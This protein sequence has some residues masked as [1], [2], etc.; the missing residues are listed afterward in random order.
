MSFAVCPA[1]GDKLIKAYIDI[2]PATPLNLMAMKP[3]GISDVCQPTK[4]RNYVSSYCTPWFSKAAYYDK[5][6]AFFLLPWRKDRNGNTYA[7]RYIV[8]CNGNSN[9]NTP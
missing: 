9:R 2:I 5:R 8:K 1:C 4:N 6:N 7:F 3:C